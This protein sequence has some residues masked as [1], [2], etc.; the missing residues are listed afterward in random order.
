MSSTNAWSGVL[1][2]V[3]RATETSW[4]GV[5]NVTIDGYGAV[6]FQSV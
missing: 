1:V 4:L 2:R 5:P 3:R 6:R